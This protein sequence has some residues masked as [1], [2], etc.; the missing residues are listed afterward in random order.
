V[1]TVVMKNWEPLVL[2]PALAMDSRP[3]LRHIRLLLAG[4]TH[5][6]RLATM[7]VCVRNI[8][9]V[10]QCIA[11]LGVLQLEVFIGEFLAVNGLATCAGARSAPTCVPA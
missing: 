6:M 5:P 9:Y 10:S 2:G 11:V 3:G 1:T 4:N 8:A 7:C